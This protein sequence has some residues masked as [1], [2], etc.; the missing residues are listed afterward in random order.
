M[1]LKQF[2]GV[3]PPTHGYVCFRC[4]LGRSHLLA[5]YARRNIQ[6]EPQASKLWLGDTSRPGPE[7]MTTSSI[8]RKLASG[9][10]ECTKKGRKGRKEPTKSGG[11]NAVVPM[12][13]KSSAPKHAKVHTIA[14]ISLCF[15]STSRVDMQLISHLLGKV[16]KCYYRGEIRRNTSQNCE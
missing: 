8:T 7:L 5:G 13:K 16:S 9:A 11:Q 1:S 15:L 10:T 12:V 14:D 3:L 4:R 2:G 6:T